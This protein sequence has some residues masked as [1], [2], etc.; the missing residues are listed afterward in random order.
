MGNKYERERLARKFNKSKHWP[1][2]QKEKKPLSNQKATPSKESIDRDSL[3]NI[4]LSH[5]GV[6]HNFICPHDKELCG[7]NDID[8]TIDDEG[9]D[10]PFDGEMTCVC[11]DN[12]AN[13]FFRCERLPDEE[14]NAFLKRNGITLS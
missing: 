13:T 2:K 11:F 8:Y 10:K 3:G 7:S 12:L 14:F 5:D 6:E 9:D 1:E 4:A